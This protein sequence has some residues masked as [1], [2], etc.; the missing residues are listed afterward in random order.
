MIKRKVK[1]LESEEIEA[2]ANYILN[3]AYINGFYNFDAHTPIDLIVEAILTLQIRFTNLNQDFEGVLG[4]LDI[5]NQIIWL[6][7]SLNHIETNNFTDEARC[8]FT[9]AHECGH[10]ILHQKLYNGADMTFFH[11]I[12]NPKTKMIETQANMFAAY[13]L[14]PTNLILKKWS[15]IDYYA[16]FEKTLFDLTRFFRVSR[17]AMVNRLKIAQLI[18]ENYQ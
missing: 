5:N 14:M 10:R 17:E 6:D 16:P 1:F 15:E 18:D 3:K 11:D 12:E 8:N 4:A 2:K 7:D 9:I 13:I